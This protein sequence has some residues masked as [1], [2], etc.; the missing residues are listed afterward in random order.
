MVLAR[1]LCMLWCLIWISTQ[2]LAIA[3]FAE[4]RASY[5]PSEAWL[6]ARNG[7]AI[8]TLRV[9]PTV[10]RLP[11]V[12]LH[13]ISPAMR[14]AVLLSED[15]RFNEHAG[16][17]WTAAAAGAWS[18][19]WSENTRGASTLSMQLVGLLEN[20]NRHGDR[21]RGRRNFLE[22]IDQTSTALLLEREWTKDQILE[23]Y[24]NLVP[25]RGEL[26]GV[27]AMSRAM[28]NKW[29][30]GLDEQEATLA[31]AMLRAPNA[32]PEIVAR[33]AC[34]L[35]KEMQRE[36]LCRDLNSIAAVSLIGVLRRADDTPRLAAHLASKVLIEPGQRLKSTLDE[37]LQR[38]TV[39]TLRRHLAGLTQRNVEDGAVLVTDNATGE[40]LAWVGSSGDLSAAENVDGVTALRQAGS[41]LKP[42]LY[43]L[44]F[45]RHHV[46]AAS[47]IEDAPL[48]LSTGN[49]LYTPQN[50]DTDYRGWV[51]VR[52]ALAGSLNVPAV[53]TLVR[54]G[55]DDFQYS[56]R[57]FGFESLTERGDWYG[58][59][60]ALGSADISLLTLNNA[61]RTLAN[62]GRWT[63][64]RAVAFGRTPC[65]E[66]TCSVF[67]GKERRVM[68]AQASFLVADIL[69]DRGARS[70]TFGLESWLSTPY[71]SA[72]KTGTSKDM[73]DNWCAGFSR[74][75]TVTVWVG[76]ASG[77]S[78]HEVSGVTGAAPVWRDVMD[79][80]HRGDEAG[81][82]RTNS[83]PPQAPLGVVMRNV[84]IESPS[85]HSAEPP[86]KEWFLAG[87]EREVIRA[88]SS[89]ALAR[90]TY[91]SEGTL[92]AVDPDIPPV[93]QRLP[94]RMSSK[95]LAGWQWR[96]DGK[97]AGL[98]SQSADWLPRPGRHRLVLADAKGA[99]LDAV[100][101]EVRALRGK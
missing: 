91:P 66:R 80:L 14:R 24:L 81:R 75:Y 95:G 13:E 85:N 63:P 58:F 32:K 52:A 94:L 62:G 30:D 42:F 47:L 96:M 39:E 50:Y 56:L 77:A 48:S 31:A 25:F 16:V 61:Y 59:S 6:L 55:P 84:R 18:N 57:N 2:A 10:R 93:R 23:A 46:T 92:I 36:S 71:W 45:E 100:N 49:G 38:F 12:S 70:G 27:G 44:A 9:D 1:R 26:V 83:R 68:S 69:S 67:S 88:A 41:T 33:R 79:W 21:K 15:R 29:P 11:W 74:R 82:R 28:F 20:Q 78:M 73:R 86:R 90:I 35:L 7:S 8:A 17:D 89:A 76:N 98:V 40:V 87:T 72:A 3:S 51:S 99:E 43:G 19:L 101:F 64:L 4:S 97:A 53:K 37:G 65:R 60:L 34:L 5:R 54:I 22:K